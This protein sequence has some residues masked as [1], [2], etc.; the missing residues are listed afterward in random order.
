MTRTVI[1]DCSSRLKWVELS[2]V[3]SPIMAIPRLILPSLLAVSMALPSIGSAQTTPGEAEFSPFLFSYPVRDEGSSELVTAPPPSPPVAETSRAQEVPAPPA[4][5]TRAAPSGSSGAVSSAAP[6]SDADFVYAG[7]FKGTTADIGEGR[8]TRRPFR[9][10]FAVNEGYNSNV[11][12]APERNR[13]E[14]LYTSIAAGVTY[15]FGSS[16]L[17]LSAALSA[18]L[19]FYY[20]NTNLQNDGIFPDVNFVLSALYDATPRMNLSFRTLTG[21]YSQPNFVVS[22][23]PS[24]YSGDYLLS[25][26][27][28]GISYQW[29][30]KFATETSYSPRFF[31]FTDQDQNDVQGRFEQTLGQQFLYLW[32]PTTAL[33]AEYRFNT[34]LYYSAEDLDS[35]GNI[36]LLGVNHSLNPRSS[37][38]ARGGV[39][40]RINNNPVPGVGGT[41]NYLGPF[42][43]LSAN[44]S[45]GRDTEFGIRAR[46]GT[47][48]SGFSFINQG[49][50]FLLATYAARQITR[51]IGANVFF[52]YQN[53][54]Y[55]QPDSRGAVPNFYDNIFNTGLIATF[56]INRVWA[57][58]A[59][60][61]FSTLISSDSRLERDYNQSMV[62]VG[63]EIGF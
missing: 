43:E 7:E 5:M 60:Y 50:Q 12:T 11:N 25:D 27:A 44:Y 32:K 45:P 59:G 22:G 38:T 55:S 15:E 34:R 23:A 4:S 62:F 19:A 51:R 48:A 40:Q 9:F 42:G 47:T 20:N 58:Q 24:G 26:S 10:N 14:S 8:F 3:L 6:I 1:F 31:Y 33:V 30:P 37:I 46:Y 49:Q 39:E 18:G 41:N 35:Y 28:F 29:L 53:N 61:S 56:Q 16:R 36:M 52:N 54:Y 63:S 21:F 17:Q 13:I 57:L 2:R